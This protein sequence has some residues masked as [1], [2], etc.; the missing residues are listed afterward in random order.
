MYKFLQLDCILEE[1]MKLVLGTAGPPE[2]IL[3]DA[4][5]LRDGEQRSPH[6]SRQGGEAAWRYGFRCRDGYEI[7]HHVLLAIAVVIGDIAYAHGVW[8]VKPE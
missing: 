7:T 8:N 4:E 1:I 5:T 3:A 2:Y 6:P